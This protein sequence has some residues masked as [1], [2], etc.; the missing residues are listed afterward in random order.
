MNSVAK[1][2]KI[3]KSNGIKSQIKSILKTLIELNKD[4]TSPKIKYILVSQVKSQIAK[5]LKRYK[6]LLKIYWAIN[7][8]NSYKQF[9]GVENTQQVISKI[10]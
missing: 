4:K 10:W 3:F 5:M 6:R 7:T 1:K 2:E 9:Y 8:K